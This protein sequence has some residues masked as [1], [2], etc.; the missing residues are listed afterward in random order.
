[1]VFSFSDFKF[2]RFTFA[3]FLFYCICV[4]GFEVPRLHQR[5]RDSTISLVP[6]LGGVDLMQGFYFFSILRIFFVNFLC[7]SLG[8]VATFD[9]T[10]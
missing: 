6:A 10:S 4:V 7:I 1:M 2:A 9:S 3:C 8:N 5:R